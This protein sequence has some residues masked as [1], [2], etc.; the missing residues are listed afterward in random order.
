VEAGGVNVSLRVMSSCVEY[1]HDEPLTVTV[2]TRPRSASVILVTDSH[3]QLAAT[4]VR[5][6]LVRPSVCPSVY[7]RSLHR[8]QS[9]VNSSHCVDISV[10]AAK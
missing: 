8:Q 10:D 7:H 4:N 1:R 5:V 3:S 6:A 9:T 2:L